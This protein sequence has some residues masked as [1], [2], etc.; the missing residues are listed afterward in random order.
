MRIE[1]IELEGIKEGG[2]FVQIG[3]N[4]GNDF[5]TQMCLKF[6]P[7]KIILIEPNSSLNPEIE[8]CYNGFNYTIENVVVSDKSGTIRLYNNP[9]T[10]HTKHYSVNPLKDWWDLSLFIDCESVLFTDLMK[11][12][13]ITEI[14]FLNIDTEG[15][16]AYILDTI[17]FNEIK[18]DRVLYEWWGFNDDCFTETNHLNGK[19]GMDYIKN[20]LNSI[21]Y[22]VSDVYSCHGNIITD[23][24]AT[25]L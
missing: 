7:S 6:K 20:K 16:D 11:K 4:V 2:V 5:F 21:G 8:K 12:H 1:E 18:I 15:N 3:T 25:R 23:Q 10:N 19:N 17:D 24:F 13:N 14:D 22:K 9:H